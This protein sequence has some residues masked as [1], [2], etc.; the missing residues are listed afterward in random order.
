MTQGALIFPYGRWQQEV[1][2]HHYASTW[3]FNGTATYVACNACNLLISPHIFS[4]LFVSPHHLPRRYEP[5]LEAWL[6]VNRSANCAEADFGELPTFTRVETANAA[7][8]THSQPEP[9]WSRMG[10]PEPRW[11]NMPSLACACLALP[12][13]AYHAAGDSH[14]LFSLTPPAL[15]TRRL[16]QVSS[17][18]PRG[19][20]ASASAR[21]QSSDPLSLLLAL[22]TTARSRYP[23][24]LCALPCLSLH[25]AGAKGHSSSIP[26]SSS[27]GYACPRATWSAFL[28]ECNGT[29]RGCPR[30][31][32][33]SSAASGRRRRHGRSARPKAH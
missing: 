33:N 5:R 27:N 2:A 11:R 14:H 15:P 13:Q 26:R 9:R 30:P 24:T 18:A 19:L 16:L 31:P 29:K 6:G 12:W 4:R 3:H 28:R 8:T 32:R 7:S 23:R 1:G 17:F 25:V 20:A 22:A 21:G 10:Q